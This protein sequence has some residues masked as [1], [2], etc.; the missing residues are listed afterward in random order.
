LGLLGSTI[1][2]IEQARTDAAKEITDPIA[3]MQKE[4]N[5]KG[6]WRFVLT[7]SDL[8]HM[9]GLK[10]LH[11]TIG[12]ANFW[13]TDHTK[14][15]P[16]FKNNADREDWEFYQTLRKSEVV[17]VSVHRF[18]RGSSAYA[19]AREEN[20]LLGGDIIEILSPSTGL[21]AASNVGEKWNDLSIVLRVRHGNRSVLRPGDA[22]TAAW[23]E[24][25]A[26]YGQQLK[27][28]YL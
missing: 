11:E 21:V 27:S 8:D 20:G 6:L 16:D 15:T 23:K 4:Y 13:D 28:D 17:G 25:A 24:M 3:F 14:L 7:H 2:L 10:N 9:R 26:I 18:I 5:G 1:S 12:F 19:F 22:E